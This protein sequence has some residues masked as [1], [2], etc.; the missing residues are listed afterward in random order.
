MSSND[1]IALLPVMITGAASVAVMLLTAFWR[2]HCA[3]VALTVAALLAAVVMLFIP[4]SGSDQVTRLLIMDNFAR[5][6]IGLMFAAA[7]AVALLAYGYQERHSTAREEFY[8]LLLLASTGAAVLAASSHFASFF[9]GLELLSVSLYGLIA[10]SRAATDGIEAGLKYLVLAAVSASFLLFGIALIY[11]RTGTMEFARLAEWNGPGSV[12]LLAGLG[13]II[14]GIGFKL[15][16]VPFHFW[17]PDV[18]Q[19]APAPVSAFI[20]TVSKGAMFALLVRFMDGATLQRSNHLILVFSLIAVASMF[21]GNL[22][23]LLQNNI[24]RLL[25]Y[26]SI[27]HLGYLLIAFI[28][29][30]KHAVPAVIFYLVAYI[31]T[32]L[33]AFGTVT[34]LS[35]GQRDADRM[36]DY[37][38]LFWRR[39]WLAGSF[40]A[41]LLSLAGIPLT[42]GFVGKFYVLLAGADSTL[43]ALV[44]ILV[45][46]SAIGLFYYLRV[47]VTI[48]S[49]PQAEEQ[50][51]IERT[52]LTA[53][54]TMMVLTVCLFGLGVVPGTLLDVIYQIPAPFHDQRAS[55]VMNRSYVPLRGTGRSSGPPRRSL[56][57]HRALKPPIA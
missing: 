18:Y 53:C 37:R 13:L 26:S 51:R 54:L 49:A 22:L 43:W 11:A 23:A 48:F 44:I 27:A 36:E 10:Y 38:A 5:F 46:N 57:I 16:L 28:A 3:V 4:R 2:N 6:F 34:I 31:I 19:G 52:P 9:L 21:A 45:I 15:A 33:I 35:N 8:V 42:A 12:T 1:L 39:P 40:T 50:V 14:V 55:S 29:S 7:I 56:A 25:A 17:T 47:I 41:A 30:G 32:M 20:A 24:K